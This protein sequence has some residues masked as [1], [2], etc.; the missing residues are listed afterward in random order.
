MLRLSALKKT[1]KIRT[2]SMG[3]EAIN[4]E[5]HKKIS[6]FFQQANRKILGKDTELKLALTCLLANGHLLI[7]DLPGMGKTTLVKVLAKLLGLKLSRIQ[8]TNDLFPSDILGVSIFEKE[9]QKF[10]FHPG[11]IFS[12]LVLGDELNRANPKTQSACLQAMEERTITWD[13]K[14]YHLP[15]PFLFIGTQ[16]PRA[17]I[18]TYSLPS[19]QLDRFLMRIKLGPPP[20]EFEKILIKEGEPSLEDL[21][22]VF[23]ISEF[24]ALQEA[25]I[26]VHASSEIIDYTMAL[27]QKTRLLSHGLSPRG[28]MS[29]LKAAKSWAF[30]H[31]RSFVIPEDMQAVALSV[32]GHRL[33]DDRQSLN[34]QDLVAQLITSIPVL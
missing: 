13:G 6:E 3:R 24:L 30:V 8:F 27:I 4:T 34:V 2:K 31:G 14:S 10:T 32:M 28:G 16:N 7:E 23:S 19:S 9:T 17:S 5:H 15:T 20:E 1:A 18:G 22:P 21:K 25:V 33:E 12:E 26:A 29:L 11:P